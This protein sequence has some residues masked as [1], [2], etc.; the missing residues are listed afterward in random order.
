MELY[1]EMGPLEGEVG[2]LWSEISALIK[3]TPGVPAVAQWDS[4][5][6]CSARTQV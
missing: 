5:H 1:L 4:W 3:E 6:L 2:A